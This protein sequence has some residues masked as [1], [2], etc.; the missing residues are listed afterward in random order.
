MTGYLRAVV[1]FS[2]LLAPCVARAE[3][4]CRDF[5]TRQRRCVAE[6][7]RIHRAAYDAREPGEVFRLRLTVACGVVRLEDELAVVR[8]YT[9]SA[10]LF[11]G[12]CQSVLPAQLLA[13]S[14]PEG[15]RVARSDL[16][17]WWRRRCGMR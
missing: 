9:P 13:Q 11:N 7:R 3:I 5:V 2:L 10:A 1:L 4:S 16:R 6:T 12:H 14:D 15:R 17:I 8:R